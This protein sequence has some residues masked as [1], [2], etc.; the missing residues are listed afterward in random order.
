MDVYR[1]ELKGSWSCRDSAIKLRIAALFFGIARYLHSNPHKKTAPEDAAEVG[2]RVL[3]LLGL[4][5]FVTC[6]DIF[7]THDIIL[8]E[9]GAGLNFDQVKLDL[10]GVF[11]SMDRTEWNVD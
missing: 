5:D 4:C 6:V 9:I 11:Q 8:S 7:V 3:V 2:V 1:I 10:A